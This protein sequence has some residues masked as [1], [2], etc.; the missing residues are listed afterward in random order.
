[1][2]KDNLR[3][4][5][6]SPTSADPEKWLMES[7]LKLGLKVVSHNL[8]SLPFGR[9]WHIS[10]PGTTGTLEVTWTPREF[11]LSVRPSRSA[12]WIEDA[13]LALQN[14]V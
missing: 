5:Q 11:Y 1:M 13:I 4:T 6:L 2:P 3:I 14:N 10:K 9:H 8:K 12:P 7:G